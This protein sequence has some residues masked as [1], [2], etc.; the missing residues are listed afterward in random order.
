ME[1]IQARRGSFRSAS[2]GAMPMMTMLDVTVSA[3]LFGGLVDMSSNKCTCSGSCTNICTGCN[4][5]CKGG[6]NAN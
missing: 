5:S 1:E 3:Q 2:K 4:G 6:N